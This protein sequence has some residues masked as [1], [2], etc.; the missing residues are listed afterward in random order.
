LAA[1]ENDVQGV[2]KLGQTGK[3]NEA[4]KQSGL[5]FNSWKEF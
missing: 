3:V 2:R 5:I 4:E 1:K